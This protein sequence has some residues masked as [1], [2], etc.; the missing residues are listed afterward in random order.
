MNAKYSGE[1]ITP[2]LMH[3]AGPGRELASFER[4]QVAEVAEHAAGCWN[5]PSRFL[6]SGWFTATLPPSAPSTIASSVVG[7]F[8]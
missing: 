1:A 6:A 3:S 8:T 7:R 4:T 2:F 5:A